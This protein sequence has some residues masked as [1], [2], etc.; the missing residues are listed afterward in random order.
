MCM[1]R[2]CSTYEHVSVFP[3]EFWPLVLHFPL[4]FPF[5]CIFPYSVF[6][7]RVC[8][9][10]K[11]PFSILCFLVSPSHFFFFFDSSM[12]DYPA[13][14]AN[15]PSIAFFFA[16]LSSLLESIEGERL[17]R[18]SSFVGEDCL[19]TFVL[20]SLFPLV[21][22][23]AKVA[24][25]LRMSEVRSSDLETGL[26]LSDDHVVL[27]ATF[28]S[29]RYKAWNILCSL[30]GKDEQRIRDRFQFPDSVKVRISSDEERACHSYADEV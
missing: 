18:V 29:T 15:S 20:S 21:S 23:S 19:Y 12:V 11:L 28:V 25:L 2:M 14:R 30:M 10:S 13:V 7:S 4:L 27:E 22:H 9:S 24:R 17:E 3:R 1:A 8:L 16:H 5:F 6:C 26:S